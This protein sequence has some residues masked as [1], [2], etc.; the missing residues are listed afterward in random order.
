MNL[1]E[2]KLLDINENTGDLTVEFFYDND[3]SEQMTIHYAKTYRD[4]VEEETN[5]NGEVTS[6][7]TIRVLKPLIDLSSKESFERDLLIYAN[8]YLKGKEL[9]G[10]TAH[11]DVKNLIES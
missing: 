11:Q 2:Y 7:K 9:E 8:S 10:K 3:T 5:E 1:K 4:I 6:L